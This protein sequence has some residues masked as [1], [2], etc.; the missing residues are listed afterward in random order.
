MPHP[1]RIIYPGAFSDPNP[2]S[3][4]PHAATSAGSYGYEYDN[5]G[6]MTRVTYNGQTDKTITWT[7][8]NKPSSINSTSFTY[9]YAGKR[10]K[11]V[12]GA[13]TTYYFD[14]LYECT[15]GTC[16]SYIFV[17]G[18]RIA[19][20]E[21]G[22]V[23]YFHKDHIQ[24]TSIESDL[25]GGNAQYCRY[26]P[27][28]ELVSCTTT[29]KYK[30][31]DQEYDSELG[32]YNYG[33]R[34][35]DPLLT[36]FMSADSIV[37]D[38]ADPQTLNRYSYCRNNPVLYMDPSGH[39]FEPFSWAA[40]IGLGIGALSSGIQSDW[41]PGAMAIGAGI[42]WV[43]GGI[44]AGVAT[45]TT[46]QLLGSVVETYTGQVISTIGIGTANVAGAA[47]GGAAG[48]MVAGGIGAAV[49][50]G[51]VLEGMGY[52]ALGGG[53]IGGAMG[54]IGYYGRGLQSNAYDFGSSA[55]AQRGV[56]YDTA[57][58]WG[59]MLTVSGMEWRTT[60]NYRF[61]PNYCLGEWKSVGWDPLGIPSGSGTIVVPGMPNCKAYWQC[62]FCGG[63]G[64]DILWSGDNYR[65]LP[66]TLG[67]R[68]FTGYGEGLK[69]G[70]ACLANPPGP[71]KGCKPWWQL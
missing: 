17:N 60:P 62:F 10:V 54:A 3:A 45:A 11:K 4:H 13:L 26:K 69:T 7:Y 66:S 42:G 51:N 46:G 49:Y 38:P 1:L 32:L 71:E 44:G 24:S 59:D 23:R 56:I 50:G 55:G 64:Q 36:R 33:A 28:G 53:I 34:E 43:S 25:N 47:A 29:E 22:P 48:G 12:V 16:S 27:Y 5:N 61:D 35:Y 70:N 6:N 39:F 15:G 68:Y 30:F 40:I 65:T 20:N 41:D 21:G 2:G 18:I 57:Q 63:A 8:D 37:P 9:D 67:R 52:G 14:P 58:G 31:T 19:K